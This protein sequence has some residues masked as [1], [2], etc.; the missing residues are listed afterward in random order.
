MSII[1]DLKARE[2]EVKRIA[3][4]LLALHKTMGVLVLFLEPDG[5]PCAFATANSVVL[6][7]LPSRLRE[8][9]DRLERGGVP[10]Q[11]TVTRIQ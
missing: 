9:A 1:V 11:P 10:T 3:E 4:N 5:C 6:S 7:L 8:I 2:N